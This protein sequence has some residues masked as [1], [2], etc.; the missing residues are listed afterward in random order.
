MRKMLML[1]ALGAIGLIG[2]C[3]ITLPKEGF[4]VRGKLS[5]T[6]LDDLPINRVTIKY[7]IDYPQE[8]TISKCTSGSRGGDLKVELPLGIALKDAIEDALQNSFKVNQN[9]YT[10]LVSIKILSIS[11]THE[12]A[13]SSSGANMDKASMSTRI[14]IQVRDPNENSLMDQT[15][16]YEEA[17]KMPYSKEFSHPAVLFDDMTGKI[18]VRVIKTISR[19][20]AIRER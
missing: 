19:T 13:A 5:G 16:D 11:S 2:G 4:V 7:T 8:P 15:V 18:A 17:L 14:N 10:Y 20:P 3:A 6:H 1:L 12:F 9:N